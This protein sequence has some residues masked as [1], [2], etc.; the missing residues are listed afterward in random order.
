MLYKLIDYGLMK[1]ST[2]ILVFAFIFPFLST[3]YSCDKPKEKTL[4]LVDNIKID[5]D[6]TIESVYRSLIGSL[7]FS[8][9]LFSYNSGASEHYVLAEDI[10]VL[11]WNKVI[12][13]KLK[14]GIRFHEGK[15][16]TADDVIRSIERLKIELNNEALKEVKAEVIDRLRFR[17][18][19]SF[20][21]P[22]AKDLLSTILVFP[23]P[24]SLFNGTGPFRFKRWV[25]NGVELEANTDYFEGAPKLKKIVYLYE[26]DERKRLA[27]LL[28]GEADIL[29][30]ISPN[31]ASFLEKD[32]RFN[33]RKDHEGFYTAL[34]L[35]NKSPI[36]SDKRVRKAVS[37]AIDR[38]SIIEKGLNGGGVSIS[39]PFPPELLSPRSETGSQGYNPKEAVRIL[40]NAG[41]KDRDGDGI[42]EKDGRKLSFTIYFHREVEELKRIADIIGQHLFEAGIGMETVR[43]KKN[44]IGN[45]SSD[46]DG[47]LYSA[48]YDEHFNINRWL[49]TSPPNEYGNLSRYVNKEVD[50]LL[51][52]LQE[53]GSAGE[54]KAI[55]GRLREIFDEDAPA[56]F[57]Y[58]PITY[59]AVSKK[60]SGMDKLGFHVYSFYRIKD[61]DTEGR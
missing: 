3:L 9:L 38:N 45:I 54:K 16:L 17:V 55:Y 42:L 18:T 44:E 34:F 23:S 51:G 11:P 25:D 40:Q 53:A 35:N 43:V 36:F 13:V 50:G 56:A 60:F 33:V 48:A 27:M 12:E 14:D 1:I 20:P 21:I 29:A 61:W 28:K 37:M 47:I 31:M 57:L 49:S 24:S 2:S 26:P 5:K 22:D 58:A 30:G 39:S 46:Y 15:P 32:V 52:Q 6:S 41:W 19:S 59:I 8:P 4:I 7:T 10:K